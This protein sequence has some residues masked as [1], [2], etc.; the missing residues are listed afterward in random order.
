MEWN[1]LENDEDGGDVVMKEAT[2]F[3][4]SF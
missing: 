2:S 3:F 4:R 1:L